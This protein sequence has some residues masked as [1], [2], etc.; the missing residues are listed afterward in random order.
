MPGDGF[1]QCRN[2]SRQTCLVG[3]LALACSKSDSITSVWCG[4]VSL[5]ALPVN[6]TM[7]RMPLLTASSRRDHKNRQLRLVLA[8]MRAATAEFDGILPPLRVFRIGQQIGN[9]CANADHPHHRRIFF[10]KDGTEAVNFQ[11]PVPAGDLRIDRP[12]AVRCGKPAHQRLNLAQFILAQRL[13]VHK[14]EAQFL[15]IHQRAFLLHM[16]AQHLAQ[17]PVG[18][19]RG[20]VILLHTIAAAPH[21]GLDRIAHFHLA[22]RDMPNMQHITGDDTRGLNNKDGVRLTVRISPESPTC[23]PISA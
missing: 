19:V 5:A 17:R 23:P 12:F 13:L 22:M 8:R 15:I 7:R 4:L 11:R 1:L 9:F 21:I 16:I 3:A 6:A 10:A 20:R 14:V 2:Q 18:Q